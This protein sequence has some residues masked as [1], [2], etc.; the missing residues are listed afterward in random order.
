MWGI[1]CGI[2]P[3]PHHLAIWGGWV[4]VEGVDKSLKR[5]GL[6]SKKQG[7]MMDKHK[8]DTSMGTNV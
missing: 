2:F 1:E 5:S 6:E 4:A 7:A 3:V 8:R